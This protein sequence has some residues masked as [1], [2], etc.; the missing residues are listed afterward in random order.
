[1]RALVISDVHGNIDAL[2]ALERRWGAGLDTFDRIVCLGDLVDYGPDP[3][4][5]FDWV[6]ARATDI[7]RWPP[8]NHVKARPPIS[9]R[10]SQRGTAF[11]PR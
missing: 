11:A 8:A 7:V 4:D 10:R 1:M 6:R 3:G 9:R 5:V 2:R